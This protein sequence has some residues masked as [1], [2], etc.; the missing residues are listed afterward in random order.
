MSMKSAEQARRWS[1]QHWAKQAAALTDKQRVWIIAN[2][3]RRLAGGRKLTN[4]E[5]GAR[6]GKSAQW[7]SAVAMAI[8]SRSRFPKRPAPAALSEQ[9]VAEFKRMW[10][11]G[12][13]CAEIARRWGY[14]SDW[15]S[16]RAQKLGLPKRNKIITNRTATEIRRRL[17]EGQSRSDIAEAMGLPR[18]TIYR[19]SAGETPPPRKPGGAPRKVNAGLADRMARQGQ[20]HGQI[21]AQFGVT[22]S[23]VT[24]AI[25]RYRKHLEALSAKKPKFLIPPVRIAA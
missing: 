23:A 7:V 17:R 6:I 5:I 21:A 8:G 20:T 15:A 13:P 25:R 2:R 11:E 24:Q 16:V 14:E 12:A 10:E 9:D 3:N 4:A 18:S 1:K 19:Y 22:R